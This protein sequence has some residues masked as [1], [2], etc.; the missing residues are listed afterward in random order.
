[1]DL[2]N[3]TPFEGNWNPLIP[4]RFCRFSIPAFGLASSTVNLVLEL[5]PLILAQ[6]VIWSLHASWRKKLGVSVIFL[7]GIMYVT[8]SP[9]N[10]TFPVLTMSVKQWLRCQHSTALLCN[11]FL[12]V[13]WHHLLFLNHGALLFVRDD[14]RQFDPMRA[15]YA[16]GSDWGPTD[17]S[18]LRAQ[19]IH[20]LKEWLQLR[21]QIRRVSRY[22]RTPLW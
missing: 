17:Q 19:T 10:H 21:H 8:T 5:I 13:E 20:E 9:T 1:M 11:T 12:R 2:V 15:F 3:C 6:K 14:M 4:G 7:I 16:E 22:Q 18:I